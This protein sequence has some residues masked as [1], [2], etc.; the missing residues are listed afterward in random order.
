MNLIKVLLAASVLALIQSCSSGGGGSST[1]QS[2]LN[3]SAKAVTFTTCSTTNPNYQISNFGYVISKTESKIVIE[4][5][6]A[7][8]ECNPEKPYGRDLE[9]IYYKSAKIADVDRNSFEIVDEDYARDKDFYYFH[10]SRIPVLDYQSFHVVI[11]GSYYAKDRIGYYYANSQFIPVDPQNFVVL[12]PNI[13]KDSRYIYDSGFASDNILIKNNVTDIANFRHLGGGYYTDSAHIYFNETKSNGLVSGFYTLNADLASFHVIADGFA[14][15]ANKYFMRATFN[16]QK[17]GPLKIFN[18]NYFSIGDK[19]YFRSSPVT[20]ADASTFIVHGEYNGYDSTAVYSSNTRYVTDTSNIQEY[21]F[22]GFTVGNIYISGGSYGFVIDPATFVYLG[23]NFYKDASNVY[24]AGINVTANSGADPSTFK[25]LGYTINGYLFSTYSFVSKDDTKVFYGPTLKSY[26]DSA[27]YQLLSHFFAK[28]SKAVYYAESGSV[29]TSADPGTFEA[30]KGN[31]GKDAVN[32]YYKTNSFTLTDPSSFQVLNTDYAKDSTQVYYGISPVAG[33]DAATAYAIDNFYVADSGKVFFRASQI[34]SADPTQFH[35]I[36]S[37]RDSSYMMSV[38]YGNGNLYLNNGNIP[39]TLT[40]TTIDLASFHFIGDYLLGDRN[41]LYTY[42]DKLGMTSQ[43]KVLSNIYA[44]SENK[45]YYFTTSSSRY[46]LSGALPDSFQVMASSYAKDSSQVYYRS[47][48]LAG[49]SPADTVSLPVEYIYD[50]DTFYYQGT[51]VSSVTDTSNMY[52]Y[53]YKFPY[54]YND[55][56]AVYYQDFPV[57]NGDT[58]PAP[59][60]LLSFRVSS[61]FAAYDV[62]WNYDRGIAT[63]HR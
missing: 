36:H 5:D 19:V 43:S 29:V 7:S 18:S 48:V 4:A 9:N 28:D 30:V 51:L 61:V 60:D 38:A 55:G 41:N 22:N 53:S 26:M 23:G 20:N 32:G 6:A 40:G 59:A 63:T 39:R 25:Y 31:F 47:N 35:V 15:D 37:F 3:P 54:Y 50:T 1:T 2:N 13:A 8:F 49:L 34:P 44:I 42:A 21:E 46:Q 17:T 33:I 45:V 16:G 14:E 11:P 24:Y 62:N 52:F 10:A 12:G 57:L 27:S 56:I 58:V